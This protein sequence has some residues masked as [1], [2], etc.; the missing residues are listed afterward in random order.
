M[1]MFKKSEGIFEALYKDLNYQC[2]SCGLRFEDN[3]T[4]KIHMKFHFE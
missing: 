2:S 1:Q 3:E 4:L